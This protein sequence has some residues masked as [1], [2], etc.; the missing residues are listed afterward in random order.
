M[1]LSPASKHVRCG[2]RLHYTCLHAKNRP[3][4]V[5][6]QPAHSDVIQPGRN[7]QAYSAR[8]CLVPVQNELEHGPASVM[9][10]FRPHGIQFSCVFLAVGAKMR[11]VRIG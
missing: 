6:T 10:S 7:W 11:R 1:L 8:A 4:A 3:A 2:S 9:R 5:E